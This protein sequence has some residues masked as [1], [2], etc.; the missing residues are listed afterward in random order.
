MNN[1]DWNM[2]AVGAGFT[3]AYSRTRVETSVKNENNETK[4]VI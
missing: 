1:K 3:L 4:P 2:R